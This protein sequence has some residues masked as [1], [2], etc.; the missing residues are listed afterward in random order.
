MGFTK[1]H[2]KIKKIKKPFWPPETLKNG[3]K[4]GFRD[5]TRRSRRHLTGDK[6]RGAVFGVEPKRQLVAVGGETFRQVLFAAAGVY[7]LVLPASL[8]NQILLQLF[9]NPSLLRFYTHKKHTAK[10]VPN[11]FLMR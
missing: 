8:T 2:I 5:G 1:I 11:R 7:A 6:P 3:L 4:T 10:S 9:H